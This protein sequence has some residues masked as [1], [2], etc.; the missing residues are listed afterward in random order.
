MNATVGT[1]ERFFVDFTLSVG[2]RKRMVSVWLEH[3]ASDPE[4]LLTELAQVL[5]AVSGGLVGNPDL[6]M[7]VERDERD[8]PCP[9]CR[10]GEV[11]SVG[12]MERET[13]HQP[14]ACNASCGYG[15]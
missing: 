15:G 2:D 7:L 10:E 4:E 1:A 13:G 3:A 5:H 8:H 14:Y 12:R 9:E 6:T 11:E